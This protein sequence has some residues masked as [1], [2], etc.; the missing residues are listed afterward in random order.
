MGLLAFFL[1]S[2][3]VFYWFPI[4]GGLKTFLLILIMISGWLSI[5]ELVAIIEARPWVA[6][7]VLALI[8]LFV[9]KWRKDREKK[10]DKQQSM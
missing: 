7:P 10:Q 5:F 6:A 4:R 9:W 2:L 3:F 1:I 8:G